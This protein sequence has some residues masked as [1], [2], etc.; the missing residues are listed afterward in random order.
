ML[1]VRS[2]AA[3]VLILAA[4]AAPP[5]ARATVSEAQIEAFTQNADRLRLAYYLNCN[6][7]PG[8]EEAHYRSC[9]NILAEV[10]LV[11][12][13]YRGLPQQLRER[14]AD[15]PVLHID[16]EPWL[17]GQA[18]DPSDAGRAGESSQAEAPP[19][20][21]ASVGEAPRAGRDPEEMESEGAA[22][23]RDYIRACIG[24]IGSEADCAAI[25][26]RFA[27]WAR[28]YELLPPVDRN[29]MVA[30]KLVADEAAAR[31]GQ[32]D[33]AGAPGAQRAIEGVPA[34]GGEAAN[35]FASAQDGRDPFDGMDRANLYLPQMNLFT[36]IANA[37]PRQ[38]SGSLAGGGGGAGF[39]NPI[40]IRDAGC[41]S[42]GA[43][44]VDRR[45]AALYESAGSNSCAVAR[46]AVVQIDAQIAYLEKCPN[47]AAGVGIES[48][49][50][51]RP[52]YVSQERQVCG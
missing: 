37:M 18:T 47:Q 31:A 14:Y 30:L 42:A 39:P 1:P 5:A 13:E 33:G 50:S 10:R 27:A 34:L 48:L 44:L 17:R 6:P 21:G 3:S 15:L 8:S 43:Q 36:S 35:S 49:R 24:G 40:E 16:P 26:R 32:T 4:F 12:G 28:D 38:G 2:L 25:G 7:W 45:I 11:Q 46:A 22:L 52:T 51:S 9:V 29:R 19:S 20:S 41:D 23:R